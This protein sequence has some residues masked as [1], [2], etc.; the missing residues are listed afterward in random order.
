MA[1]ST[2]S[3]SLDGEAKEV[4]STQTGV[5]LF[6]DDKN[7]IAVKI[8]G[9]PKDLYA[10]LHDGDTVEPIALDS[11]DGIAIMR[12]SCTHVMA[13]AVQIIRPDAKLGIGPVID[14]GFYYDFDVEKPFTPEDLKAIDK[15]MHRIIKSS[16]R[17]ER[18]VVTED[19]A[20]EEE[21]DQPYKLELI[22][23]KEAEI[24]SDAQTE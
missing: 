16:Q 12:H 1:Q 20:R 11:V 19:E 14:D 9:T 13:Q 21:K 6:A 10:S 15:E 2:I 23:V 8:N 3:I 4:E 17:F 5:D 24:D 22:G 18:R 7:I